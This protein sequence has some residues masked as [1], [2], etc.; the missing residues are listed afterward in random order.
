M[1]YV[2]ASTLTNPAISGFADV[3]VS[4]PDSWARYWCVLHSDCLYIYQTQQST[5]TIK[6]VVLPG[7]DVHVADPLTCK[8]QYAILLSHNGVTPVCL[9]VNDELELNQWLSLLDKS[10]RA[11]GLKDATSS[12]QP[13]RRSSRTS[14][15]EKMI[16]TGGGKVTARGSNGTG[17]KKG[18]LRA[19]HSISTLK[20]GTN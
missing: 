1:S 12:K 2:A 14:M 3:A 11:E 6:T 10:A 20:V 15:E 18:P 4:P 9:A 8:R 19:D 13:E 16:L 17:K 5:A 7:Y